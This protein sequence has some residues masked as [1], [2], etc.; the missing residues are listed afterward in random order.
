MRIILPENISERI[1]EFLIGKQDFPFVEGYEL[2]CVLFL[3]GRPSK[4]D[5]NEKWE[6]MDLAS[7]TVN[8][9]YLEI[10]SYKNSPKT[11]MNTELIRRRRILRKK[12]NYKS[13]AEEEKDGS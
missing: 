2:M 6:V 5:T 10:E 9:F 1:G 4:V 7:E 13:G 3:F 8:K 12:E 11:R